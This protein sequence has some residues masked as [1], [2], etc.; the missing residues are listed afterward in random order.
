MCCLRLKFSYGNYVIMH[1]LRGTLS[2]IKEF[3]LIQFVRLALQILK[4]QMIYLLGALWC[5]KFGIVR[6][7]IVSFRYGLSDKKLFLFGKAY[8]LCLLHKII[9]L[10]A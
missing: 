8:M 2:F 4:M 5:R 3:N 9:L 10:L 6:L 7:V 1:S